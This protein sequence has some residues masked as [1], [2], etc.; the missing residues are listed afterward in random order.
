MQFFCVLY[1]VISVCDHVL[2]RDIDDK[3]LCLNLS[4]TVVLYST[5]ASKPQAIRHRQN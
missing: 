5:L 3:T 2:L 1:H 4:E